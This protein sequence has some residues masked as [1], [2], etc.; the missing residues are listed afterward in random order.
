MLGNSRLHASWAMSQSLG[1]AQPTIGELHGGGAHAGVTWLP[2]AP[3][4]LN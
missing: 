3:R 1:A 2:S 4:R